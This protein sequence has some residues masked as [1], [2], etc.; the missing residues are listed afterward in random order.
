MCSHTCFVNSRASAS[1]AP[2]FLTAHDCFPPL[3]CNRTGMAAS[4]W[5]LMLL[6]SAPGRHYNGGGRFESVLPP[7]EFG[8]ADYQSTAH[9]H[10]FTKLNTWVSSCRYVSILQDLIQ[11]LVN[12]T[13]GKNQTWFH[14]YVM[15]QVRHGD[16]PWYPQ[17]PSTPTSLRSRRQYMGTEK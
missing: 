10:T 5:S 3:V 13:N 12:T 14:H 16:Q 6:L 4:G 7:I 1:F 11:Q 8:H 17:C 15:R 9:T 2:L